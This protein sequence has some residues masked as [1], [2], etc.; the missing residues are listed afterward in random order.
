M[1]F[2]GKEIT[3]KELSS[4]DESLVNEFFDAMGGESRALFNRREYNRKRALR[5]C[6][7]PDKTQKY[8][9]FLLEGKM[10][11]MLFFLDFHT[12]MPELGIAVRDGLSGQGLGGEVMRYAID[13]AR[14]E[15]AGAIELTTHAANIRAQALYEKHGFRCIGPTKNGTELYYRLKLVK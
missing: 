3:V 1:K 7:S 9:A 2:Q 12:M 10:A 8:Y 13:E 15:G 5:Y 6:K 4:L 14:K 11:A